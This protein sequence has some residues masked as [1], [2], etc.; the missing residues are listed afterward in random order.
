MLLFKFICVYLDC[1]NP[2]CGIDGAG[3]KSFSRKDHEHFAAGKKKQLI[4]D[5]EDAETEVVV[6]AVRGCRR[7]EPQAVELNR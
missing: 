3:P 5:Y 7:L 4:Q 2:A 1:K 6:D